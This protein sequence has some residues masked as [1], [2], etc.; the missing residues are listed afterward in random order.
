MVGRLFFVRSRGFSL[1][2]AILCVASMVHAG[3]T[4]KGSTSAAP[5]SSAANLALAEALFAEAKKLM[6]D[7]KYADA[8]LKLEESLRLDHAL[9]TLMNL[10]ECYEKL[11]RTASAWSAFEA[12]TAEAK[13]KNSDA[14]A[15]FAQARADALVPKL[16]RLQI[17]VTTK[18]DGLE[19]KR[20]GTIVGSGLW[21]TAVPVDPGAHVVTATA[22]GRASW[23]TKVTLKEEGTT[24]KVIVPSLAIK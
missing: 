24:T 17:V 21:D 15:K 9:G 18:H 6:A 12:A 16:S 14:R 2:L 19:I 1:A 4:P 8:A 5:S 13:A 23:S 3:P 7:G 11:G 22:P 10:G 20:D